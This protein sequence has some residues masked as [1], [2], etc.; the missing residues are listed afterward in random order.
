MGK[1]KGPRNLIGTIWHVWEIVTNILIDE[2]LRCLPAWLELQGDT[3]TRESRLSAPWVPNWST[4]ET[5]PTPPHHDIEGSGSH[6]V[7]EFLLCLC[8]RKCIY[9][10]KKSKC[11]I[12]IPIT[13]MREFSRVKVGGKKIRF[14]G[15]ST[16][17][18]NETFVILSRRGHERKKFRQLPAAK[19]FHHTSKL[20]GRRKSST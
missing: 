10:K 11:I 7:L 12:N 3:A 9:L 8:L 18:N 2:R 4:P 6:Y 17:E 1:I 15:P 20:I 5:I 19:S 16:M 14:E 13:Q